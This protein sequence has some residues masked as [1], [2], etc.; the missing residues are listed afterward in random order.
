MWRCSAFPFCFAAV[1]C[2][3]YLLPYGLFKSVVVEIFAQLPCGE[4]PTNP[5]THWKIAPLE[6]VM[7]NK[8]LPTGIVVKPDVLVPTDPSL[9]QV[10]A[11]CIEK[12]LCTFGQ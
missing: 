8:L 12:A 9:I 2:V 10:P 4:L 7:T 3:K 5:V 1:C 6:F 11:G